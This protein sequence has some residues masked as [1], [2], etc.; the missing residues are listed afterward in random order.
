MTQLSIQKE[1]VDHPKAQSGGPAPRIRKAGP[2]GG[3]YAR[4]DRVRS[5]DGTPLLVVAFF[6]TTV[7]LTIVN[8]ARTVGVKLHV[9]R[10]DLRWVVAAY[11]LTFGGFPLLGERA[12]A[13]E[14]G[15]ARPWNIP[16]LARR[17][18]IRL[19]VGQSGERPRIR[20]HAVP[21]MATRH[22]LHKPLSKGHPRPGSPR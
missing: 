19:I 12:P 16:A 14:A 2:V 6:I 22:P 21:G 17:A 20:D 8:V 18:R 3:Q 5:L 10:S 7:D 9:P 1:L 4:S 11:A 13:V 15:S